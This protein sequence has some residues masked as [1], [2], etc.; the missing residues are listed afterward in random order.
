M[1]VNLANAFAARGYPTDLVSAQAAGVYLREVSP[2]VRIVDLAARRVLFSLPSLVRYLRR[3]RPYA[4]LSALTH[5]NMVALCSRA[6]ARVSTRILVSERNV[7]KNDDA[8]QLRL[9]DRLALLLMK[10]LYSQAEGA[11]AVAQGVA[12]D[13][14]EIIGVQADRVHTIYNPVVTDDIAELAGAPS[15]HPWLEKGELPVVL[16]VG[17]LTEQKDFETLI[18]AFRLVRDQRPCR[19]VILGEGEQRDHLWSL[20]TELNLTDCVLLPGFQEN[21]FAWMSRAAVFVLSSRWEGLPGVLIQAMACGT[22]VVST[23]CHSGP[24]EILENGKW[25]RLVPLSDSET[26]AKEIL[27]TLTSD[28]HPDVGRRAADFRVERSVQN[29]LNLLLSAE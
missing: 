20:V 10:R 26:M 21:P 8:R 22:P 28:T 2:R 23:D 12:T 9:S 15:P 25:G 1:M 29:Y 27:A 11:V 17:R 7:I 13:L 18:R 19:L 3:E 6:I 4:M 5:A 24:R 14:V 16:G